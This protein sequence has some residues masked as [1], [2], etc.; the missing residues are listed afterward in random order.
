MTAVSVPTSVLCVCDP[1]RRSDSRLCP[2]SE[3]VRSIL[4]EAVVAEE[5]LEE[6]VDINSSLLSRADFL[7]SMRESSADRLIKVNAVYSHER[8][9]QL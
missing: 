1:H 6:G 5:H 3:V 9:L 7:G 2:D 8:Q 4:L